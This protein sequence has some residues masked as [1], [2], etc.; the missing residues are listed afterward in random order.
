MKKILLALVVTLF[1]SQDAFALDLVYIKG[2]LG[3]GLTTDG[4]IDGT[5]VDTDIAAPYPITI[6]AGAFVS[7][8]FSL[9]LE[10]NYET[11][12]I[13]EIPSSV[14]ED[15]TKQFGALLNFYFHFPTILK[16]SPFIGAGA[17]YTIVTLTD[18]DYEGDGFIWLLT[19]GFD[20]NLNEF[21][22]LTSEVRFME[23]LDINLEDENGDPVGD[24]NF[25]QAKLLVGLKIKI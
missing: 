19:A 17:G 12:E 10:I 16:I 14:T 4:T 15:D 25:S 22:S 20:V 21:L 8:L 5:D 1:S 23:P 3:V 7:P 2:M 9:G 13:T 11:A 24:F 6:G 18:N